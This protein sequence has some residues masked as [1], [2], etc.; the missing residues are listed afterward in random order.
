MT[1]SSRLIGFFAEE[2][3]DLSNTWIL[4]PIRK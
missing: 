2:E 1:E 4:V 3:G